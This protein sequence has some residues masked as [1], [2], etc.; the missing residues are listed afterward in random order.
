MVLTV[1]KSVATPF[2]RRIVTA[3]SA[4][5]QLTLNVLPA[6]IPTKAAGP[7]VNSTAALVTAKATE[8][9]RARVKSIL[10]IM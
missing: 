3:P 6:V 5:D 2:L 7:I 8:A 1:F 10:S 4:P 9:K